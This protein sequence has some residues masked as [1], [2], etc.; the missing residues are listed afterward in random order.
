MSNQ[1]MQQSQVSSAREPDPD[2]IK[3]FVGQIPRSWGEAECR[4][5]FEQF[6]SVCQLNVLR[7]KVTQASRGCC[8]VTY[9]K[10]ADAIAAQAALHNIRVL[11]QMYHPVQMKPAD[12]ENRNERKLFVGMLNKKLTEDSVRE[13]FAQFGHIED[14]TVLKDSE[15]KSRGCAFVTFAHRSCAQ[16]AIRQVHLSQTMEGCSKPIVVK[17]ADTQKEKDAK[18]S[19]GTPAVATPSLQNTVSLANTLQQLL[20]TTQP[21]SSTSPA[22]GTQLAALAALLQT[23]SQPNVLSLLGNVLSGLGRLTENTAASNQTSIKSSP[24]PL[25]GQQTLASLSSSPGLSNADSSAALQ[26]QQ[27]QQL[28]ALQQ[29]QRLLELLTHQ[30]LANTPISTS[31]GS[32]GNDSKINGTAGGNNLIQLTGQNTSSSIDALQQA[33]AGLQQFAGLYP[34]LSADNLL[35][36]S[37]VSNTGVS[38]AGSGQSKGPDGCNLFIYHLPQDFTDNDL[39]TTFSPFGSIISAKVFIDKQT[40]LSKCFGFVSY[41]NVVSAQNAISAL[42]GFQIG[43][44]RLKVQ[45]KRGKDNKPYPSIPVTS[46]SGNTKP[47]ST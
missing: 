33:Y 44:K 45:L 15:G 17:F 11:P 29:Q 31:S 3:M 5:L 12:I 34:Q 8:F 1:P 25:V 18:K 19:G 9:Y 24:F 37:S 47:L 40:N 6:G 28:A 22:L 39:Y 36:A 20:Q 13:M 46:N 30:Q 27:H 4:E 23:A 10:R 2:A 42:N 26:Q 41:D 14:C 43:S 16:Q 21:N 32:F 35:T 7:D 38:T